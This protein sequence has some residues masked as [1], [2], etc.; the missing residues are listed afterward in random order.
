MPQ[1]LGDLNLKRGQ[2]IF[3]LD[4]FKQFPNLTLPKEFVEHVKKSK[5]LYELNSFWSF[6]KNEETPIHI[7]LTPNDPLV[8]SELNGELIR[9]HKQPG[10]FN[11]VKFTDLK[12]THC[13]LAAEYQWPF[14]VEL[15]RRGLEIK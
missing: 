2:P 9:T 14:L 3:K 15:I 1:A 10:V 12:G 8:M 6:Y 13:A 7:Y 5:T 11:K 4:N